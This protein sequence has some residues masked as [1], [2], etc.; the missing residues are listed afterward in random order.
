MQKLLLGSVDRQHTHQFQSQG[1]MSFKTYEAY[2]CHDRLG[3]EKHVTTQ[4]ITVLFLYLL[5]Y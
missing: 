4:L 5:R 1:I 2:S 3:R